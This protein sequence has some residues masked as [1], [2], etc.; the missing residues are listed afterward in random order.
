MGAA[1]KRTVGAFT[2][3]VGI[4]VI[5]KFA[6]KDG[7]DHVAQGVVHHPVAERGRGN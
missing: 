5:D 7:L 6:F 1:V 2:Q 3:A 4:R